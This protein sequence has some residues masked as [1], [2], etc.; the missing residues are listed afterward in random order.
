MG[1]SVFSLVE[2]PRTRAYIGT[3]S[4]LDRASLMFRVGNVTLEDRVLS[5]PPTRRGVVSWQDIIPYSS[6]ASKPSIIQRPR[7][8][9]EMREGAKME[10]VPKLN[11]QSVRRKGA[12]SAASESAGPRTD[13]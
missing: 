10:S 11:G 12:E 1:P 5:E 13:S 4:V 8:T 7:L 9:S 2:K 6:S 3:F